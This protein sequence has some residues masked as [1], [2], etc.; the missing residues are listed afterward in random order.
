MTYTINFQVTDFGTTTGLVITDLVPDGMSYDAGS[1]SLNIGG[2]M[3]ITPTVTP[4][5][6]GATTVIYDIGAA[7]GN[8]S[9]GTT[10]TL[11]YTATVLQ[12]IGLVARSPS[13]ET[14]S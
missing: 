2:A 5:A 6:D 1:A 4:N 13:V 14:R 10:G 3:P 12:M 9:P 8:L 7:A 11:T